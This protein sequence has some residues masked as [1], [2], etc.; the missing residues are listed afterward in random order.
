MSDV[1]DGALAGLEQL[2]LL[3][4][5]GGTHFRVR[6]APRAA[7]EALLG[8]HDGALKV[9]LTAPPVE[10]AANDA[11]VQFLAKLLGAP[12]RAVSVL[13]GE[14]SRSKTLRVEGMPASAVR[15]ALA[16]VAAARRG[17]KSS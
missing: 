16:A 13:H 2:E 6:V 8:V 4:Q 10:G 17:R 3:E 15:A 7:R 11:L 14:H 1:V 9:S 12:R 5:S